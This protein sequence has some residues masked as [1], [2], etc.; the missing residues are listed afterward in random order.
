MR[1]RL[2]DLP[3]H[4]GDIA[5]R[6]P[7]GALSSDDAPRG[8]TVAYRATCSCGWDGTR[9][10]PPTDEGR[11]SAGSEW[12]SHMKPLWAAAAPAWLLNRSDSMRVAV[13]E[14]VDTWPLQALGVLND[15][16]KWHKTLTEQA[17]ATARKSGS[18]W[19]EIGGA[20]GIAKQSAHERFKNVPP[21][22]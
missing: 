18:S 2:D 15:I 19:A 14:L 20:M 4:A 7:D 16:E 9:D 22:E 21:A 12:T 8:D 11:M 17:V 3:G 10:Y 1:L 5:H 13:A 6:T